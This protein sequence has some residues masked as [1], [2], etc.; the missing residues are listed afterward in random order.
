[1]QGRENL[2]GA[3]KRPGCMLT[4]PT[5]PNTY[6]LSRLLNC[7]VEKGLLCAARDGP[8]PRLKVLPNSHDTPEAEAFA[9]LQHS[10]RIK[11][12]LV[13]FRL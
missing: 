2:A 13:L 3:A 12:V 6:W 8:R 10:C 4:N 7:I 1:M 11:A 5:S 9:R